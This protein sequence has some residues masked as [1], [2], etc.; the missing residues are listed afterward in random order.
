MAMAMRAFDRLMLVVHV[1]TTPTNDE[2]NRWLELTRKR[3]GKQARVLVETH[4]GGPN[5]LQRKALGDLVR[6]EDAMRAVL[7]DSSAERTALHAIAWHGL[8]LRCFALG[9]YAE[10]AEYLKLTPQELKL[11]L[12]VLPRL[13]KECG[14]SSTLTPTDP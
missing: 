7:T 4:S 13:R 3:A 9:E 6:G 1:G 5:V 11:T 8:S 14:L 2:W 12:E 10:A